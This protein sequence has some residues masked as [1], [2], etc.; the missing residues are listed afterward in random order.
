MEPIAFPTIFF[1]NNV[2]TL[3]TVHRSI[4]GTMIDDMRDKGAYNVRLTGYASKSGNADYNLKLSTQ[5]AEAVRQGLIGMGIEPGRVRVVSGGID[6]QA[7][8]LAAGRRVE[9]LAI[10]K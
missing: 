3:N 6:F 10:P 5:R 4:L 9:V 1:D 2:S 7:S 8:S